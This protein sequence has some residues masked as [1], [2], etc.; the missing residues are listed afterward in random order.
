MKFFNL[1]K[2]GALILSSQLLLA[3][4]SSMEAQFPSL[5]DQEFL[6]QFAQSQFDTSHSIYCYWKTPKAEWFNSTTPPNCCEEK[7]EKNWEEPKSH[8]WEEQKS[9][10]W[11]EPKS[12]SWEEPK[13]HSWKE[14]KSH[15]CKE[16][17]SHCCKEQKFKKCDHKPRFSIFDKNCFPRPKADC[18]I[19]DQVTKRVR[20]LRSCT[21]HCKCN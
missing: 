7:E 16:Q 6:A 9:H 15:C 17:K 21:H 19:R 2:L 10:S 8:S 1:L 5:S 14:P 18:E 13:S 3:S 4:E 11:E 12:H 20:H